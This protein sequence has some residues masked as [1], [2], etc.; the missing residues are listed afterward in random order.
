MT[1][2]EKKE[3]IEKISTPTF[4]KINMDFSV[5]SKEQ[6]AFISGF[7]TCYKEVFLAVVEM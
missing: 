2:E 1:Q 7:M 4:E 6:R 5:K 3:F